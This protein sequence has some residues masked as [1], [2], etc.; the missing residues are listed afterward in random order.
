MKIKFQGT[1]AVINDIHAPFQDQRALREV[2]LFLE[3]VQ[4]GLLIKAGDLNDFYLISNFDKN[5]N[6]ADKLQKDLDSTR[7]MNE[8]QRALLPNSRQIAIDGNHEDRLR[9][10]LWGKAPALASLR[11]LTVEEL[12]GLNDNGIEHVPYEEGLFINDIFIVTHGDMVRAH[13]SF[14]AKGMSDKHGGCGMVGHCH[15]L[16]SYYKRDRFGTYGW[17]EN[18]CLSLLTPDWI[19]NPNWQQGFSLIHF[20][21]DR[22]WVEPIPII[23]RRFMYGGRMFG[24]GGKKRDANGI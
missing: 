2:E 9:R 20:K 16:G 6:R 11:S 14:T 4:P 22:F 12:Y 21:G 7:R 13:S 8:R 5:P 17:W 10:F 23:N 19:Q 18:G 1:A 3:E 24:S 15:R